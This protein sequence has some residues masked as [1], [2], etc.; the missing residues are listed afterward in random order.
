MFPFRTKP[1]ARTAVGWEHLM[2][3]PDTKLTAADKRRVEKAIRRAKKEGKIAKT[4][5]QTIPYE[6]MYPDGICRITNRLYS[7]SVLCDDINYAEASDDEKAVLFELYCKLVNYFGP[8]VGFELSVICYPADLVEY[9]KMLALNPQGDQFDEIRKEYSDM[10]VRQV[11]KSRYERRICLTYTIEADGIRQARSRLEQ[12][13]NDVVGH[14]RALTVAAHP[15]D[16]YERLT[17]LH[18]CLHLEENR[19]FRFNWDSLNHT[20]LSS[21]DYI[22]PSSFFFKD[23]R[24]FRS[25]ASFGA[26]SFLQIR[27][28][29]L[30]DTLLNSIL[31]MEGSQIVSIHAKALD[32]NAALKAVKRKLSDLDKAKIDEQKRAVRSGFDMDIL[33]PDL[34]TF[35]KEA[36]KLLEDLQNHD[37]KMFMVTI[38]VVHA[39]SSRQKLENLIYSANGITN[40]QNCD[41][42]RLDYQQ[43]QGFV[44]ALPIGI[45]QVEIQRGLTTSGTAIFLPFRACEVFQPKGVYYGLNATT[46]RMILADRKTLKCPNGV[47]LGTPGSGKSFS[48]KR[49]AADVY[50]HTTDDLLFLDPENEYTSLCQQLSGQV[51]RLA[52][53]SH[54]YINPLDVDLTTNTGENPLLMKADFIMSFCE[55][56]L[57]AAQGGLKPIE[58]SVIDRCIPKIY[59]QL[60]KDPRPENMPILGDL[61]ECLR[62]QQEEQAQ[63]LATALELY[64]FGSLNYLNHRTNVN[65]DN[66]VACYDI[67]GLGQNLK[68]PGMLTVQ[69]NIWQRTIVN[70]Y[71]GKTTRIYLDE[72]HLLLKEPQTAAYTAE[73]YKRFRKWNGIPTSLTQNVKDLLESPEIENILENSDFILML[74]QAA[75]DRNILAQRL[76][77]SPQELGHITN[78]DA[79]EGLLFFGDIHNHIEFNSTAL[80]CS[81]KFNNVKNSFL[82]LRKANDRICQEFGLNI[83]EEPQEK[84]KHYVEWAAEKTGKSW[85]NLLRKNI[86]RI[87]P[88]VKTFDEFLEAMRQEGYEVVQSKKIL[89]FR[90]QGQERFTRS[91]ILGADYTLEV[92]QERIGKTQLPRRK[93]KVNLQKDTRINLLMDIQARLQGRGPGMERWMKIHNLKEAAKT[94]NYL[95]EH[96]ITEYDVLASRVETAAADFETVSISIKQME[97]RMEQI[98]AL[99][100]HIINYAKTRNT[101]LAYR[102]TKAADKPAFR[103]AHET[104]LLLHEAAKRAFDALGVKKLPT[105]KVLQA[106]YTDLLAKKKAAYEDFK[107]LRQE[108]QELQAVKSNVDS[109]LQIK[110][111]EKKEQKQEKK[112]EQDR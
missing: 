57:S 103:A 28:T 111:E 52:P 38:L 68:K 98:A 77:I 35:G 14:F 72:F 16:G 104:D 95:T 42:I 7:K 43:E 30:Y 21:K 37:E 76:G 6:E 2:I 93:K 23:G 92:L 59:R 36:Q 20:G 69:N 64:V 86:D 102:K 50:L 34:V 84:G 60:I 80:D 99:K 101:Y 32:Q 63:E 18:R 13:D 85:K 10:L 47:V 45:N 81:H 46:N 51:I 106:E 88:T 87:L 3:R 55:L 78:S 67:S 109:L 89:K 33:P 54:D 112:Q 29:K 74:N 110:Q 91:R 62:A 75:S 56:I 25:G 70:R 9:R 17:I 19:K 96:G 49:E 24:Y 107:R 48:C 90:A 15:M 97:H 94:L 82:P 11:S 53:D 79:G 108:N 71:A 4:A 65:V 26:V 5:Q 22:A 40:T 41:L 83:I 66:R 105:V 61:Y 39:A 1:P 58:K 44:S 31:N 27:A 12:I 100:T 8:S 73:I